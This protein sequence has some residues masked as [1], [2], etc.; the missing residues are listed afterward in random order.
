MP[1]SVSRRI[2]RALWISDLH[3]GSKYAQVDAILDFLRTNRARSLYLVGDIVD[4][5][6][7]KRGWHWDRRTNTVIQK[8]LRLSRK[9]TRVTY[10]T[11]NH[12]DFL[13][14]YTGFRFGDI[15]LARHS[16]HRA[17]D[18]RRYLVIH[19]HQFDGLTGMNRLLERLGASAYDWLLELNHHTSRIRRALGLGHWSLSAYL[20]DRTKSA[21]Q[22]ITEY[23]TALRRLAESKGVDGVICGHIHRAELSRSGTMHYLN[24]GDWVES[25]TALA[26]D[27][28]GS[29]H[30]IRHHENSLYGAGRGPGAPH[31]GPRAL[32]DPLPLGA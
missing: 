16:V 26:E 14:P 7:L 30:L 18:G 21:V 11:G 5:W 24:C 22:Y 23:E 15:R 20:K 2:W 25:C 9:G 32:G 19:G 1:A 12:D 10:I 8:L 13:E 27:F 28:D 31:A 6:E 29:F 17:A 3:L 4:G